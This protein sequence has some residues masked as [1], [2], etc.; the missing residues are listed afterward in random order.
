MRLSL[1]ITK[2]FYGAAVAQKSDGIL[3]KP[4]KEGSAGRH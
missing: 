4:S 1:E 2:I 3:L